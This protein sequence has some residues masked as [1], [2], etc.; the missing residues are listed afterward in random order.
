MFD[1]L[2]VWIFLIDCLSNGH[3]CALEEDKQNVSWIWSANGEEVRDDGWE[4]D[5]LDI[6]LPPLPPT[7]MAQLAWA[8]FK[9]L[10]KWGQELMWKPQDIVELYWQST[11]QLWTN[12]WAGS[13]VSDTY[14]LSLASVPGEP[15]ELGPYFRHFLF[16][17]HVQAR[18]DWCTMHNS[19]QKDLC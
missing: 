18:C 16:L 3:K 9:V 14:H 1:Y 6:K 15:Q 11:G 8:I 7:V 5:P 19:T 4:A 17:E 13:W 12:E 10:L 2:T